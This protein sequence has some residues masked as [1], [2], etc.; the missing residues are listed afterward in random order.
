MFVFAANGAQVKAYREWDTAHNAVCKLANAKTAIGGRITW[1]FTPT[2]INT[3]L[4]V[5]CACGEEKYL[6]DGSWDEIDAAAKWCT[7]APKRKVSP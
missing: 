5:K 4:T 7:G 6:D 2:S 1:M 3:V